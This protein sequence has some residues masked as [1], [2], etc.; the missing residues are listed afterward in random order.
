MGTETQGP[1]LCYMSKKTEGEGAESKALLFKVY[2]VVLPHATEPTPMLM[3]CE[4][5]ER[6]FGADP[7]RLKHEVLILPATAS[8]TPASVDVLRAK[9]RQ[10]G[11][12]SDE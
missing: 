12:E 6:H 3:Y 1:L 8:L 10:W 5:V 9:A 4:L 11:V 2:G 7:V